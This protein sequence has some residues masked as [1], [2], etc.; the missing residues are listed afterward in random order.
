MKMNY[1]YLNINT[2]N[3]YNVVKIIENV[4]NVGLE[5]GVKF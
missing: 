4:Y 5:D 2:V 1:S 3:D